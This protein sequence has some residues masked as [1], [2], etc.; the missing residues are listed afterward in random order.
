MPASLRFAKYR[1]LKS[2]KTS[3]WD[4]YESLPVDY[5][6]VFQFQN[7]KRSKKRVMDTIKEY[8]IS[9]GT[10]VTIVLRNGPTNI[11][12]N[13]NFDLETPYDPNNP[14][15]LFALLPYE[16]KVSVV[17]FLVKKA[18][19]YDTPV[20]SKDSMLLICGFRTFIVHPIY[21]TYTR[22]GPNNVHKFERFLGDGQT[23]ATIYAPKIGRAHV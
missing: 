10:F 15:A 17:N 14:I 5:G 3:A 19:S 11:L 2:F 7:F 23:V 6:R 4:P 12:S 1:G 16:H 13:A 20:K 8:D 18:A 21:S 9:P 22:G